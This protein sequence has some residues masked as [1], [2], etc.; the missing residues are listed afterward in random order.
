MNKINRQIIT[1]IIAG[2]LGCVVFAM[3]VNCSNKPNEINDLTACY[4]VWAD[5]DCE[6]VQTEKYTLLFERNNDKISATLRQNERVGEAIYSNFFSGFVFDVKTKEY[7]KI[8]CEDSQK[9]LLIGDY[10]HL[11]DGQLDVLQNDQAGKLQLV[12]KITVCPAYE[13]P[14]AEDNT[15][16]DCLQYWQLGTVE[17]NLDPENLH[18]EIGTNKHVYIFLVNSN[19]LYCRAARIRHNNHGSVFAQNIRLM[20]N[21]NT[22]E[23]TANMENNN[24][25]I[26]AAEVTINDTLFKPDMCSYEDGGIYWSYIS[27]V[28]NIIAVNGCGETYRFGRPTVD[29]EKVVEWFK[30]KAY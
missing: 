14:F 4:G 22:K 9:R 6:L 13:M 23:T 11:K 21:A 2:L 28:P 3:N 20:I 27:S 25:E 18:I 29:N 15:I 30:Y 19:M 7:E 8:V 24:L 5:A 16:G 1:K 10:I 26:T 12:E 17:Y